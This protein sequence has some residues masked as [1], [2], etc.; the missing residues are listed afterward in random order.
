MRSINTI[1]MTHPHINSQ[2]KQINKRQQSRLIGDLKTRPMIC[3]DRLSKVYSN[4]SIALQ[5]AS[6]LIQPGEFVSIV[7][8]S[9]SGKTTLVKLLIGEERPSDGT[10]TVEFDQLWNVH[11]IKKR[12][13][14]KYRRN[15]G[16]VFQD[17]RLL[18]RKTAYE[19]IAFGMEVS[20]KSRKQIKQDVP[21]M[22]DLVSLGDKADNFPR[23]MS[24]GE[25]Q[26]VAIARAMINKPRLLI[27]DEPTGDLDS[28][29]SW[30]IVQLLLKINSLGTTVIFASHARDIVNMINKRVITLDD[31]EI[32]RSQERGKYIL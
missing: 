5:N 25:Q 7:G 3:I 20:E 6:L 13:K 31:G 22:L 32:I 8:K 23:Q 17:F 2:G 18:E 9:G 19:N 11:N 26:R 1:H 28:I 29:N 27:A 21:R 30:E 15:I 24:G 4:N 16:V 10:I 14:P 12:Q